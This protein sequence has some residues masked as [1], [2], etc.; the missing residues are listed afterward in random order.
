MSLSE[1]DTPETSRTTVEPI[2]I[3]NLLEYADQLK[4]EG[5]EHFKAGKWGEALASYQVA[6][7][8][9][10]KRKEKKKAVKTAAETL[11]DELD[12]GGGK[13]DSEAKSATGKRPEQDPSIE[14]DD[15]SPPQEDPFAKTRATLNANIAACYMKLGEDKEVVAACSQSLLDDPQYVKALQ[16]RATSNERI[17]SWSSLASAQEDY[18]KLV[19]LLPEASK[20]RKDA[21]RKLT[22]LKPRVEEA[23]KRETAE[24][25]GQLKG[26]GNSI[27]GT[28][29]YILCTGLAIDLQRSH[30][31]IRTIDR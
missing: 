6:L 16:R 5:N 20:D 3:P 14:D 4:S 25:L 21:E 9:L 27:L 23:Q 31:E 2:D 12:E 11:D 15:D 18:Q 13:D 24:M 8:N 28:S 1:S 22:L 7:G 10:P 26:I 19:E 17:N 30:R 29:S